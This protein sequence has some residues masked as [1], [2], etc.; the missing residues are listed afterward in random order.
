MVKIKILEINFHRNGV[1]GNG[2]HAVLFKHGRGKSA[3]KMLGIVFLER[4]NIAVID[5]GLLA[6]E[7]GVG[8]GNRWCG[9]V[10]E[11]ALRAA[12]EERT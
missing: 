4:G 5:V 8:D 9:D 11:D 2:F 1:A 12:L 3:Q 10:F 7:E 6:T